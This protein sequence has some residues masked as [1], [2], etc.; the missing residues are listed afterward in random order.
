[1]TKPTKH[2]SIPF[3]DRSEAERTAITKE[4]IDENR[5]VMERWAALTAAEAE[6]WSAR[7]AMA[8]VWLADECS[9]ADLGCATMTLE[10]YLKP[11]QKYIPVDVVARDHR[12]VVCDFNLEAP[13][14]TPAIAAAC[15]GLIEYIHTPTNFMALIGAQYQT[16]VVSYC[17]TD[18]PAAP[19][20]RRANAWVND[21]DTASIEG[22]FHKTGWTIS[23]S[24]WVD[25]LQRIWLLHRTLATDD[26]SELEP[27]LLFGASH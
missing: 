8:A 17:V 24:R 25:D 21:F 27:K 16:T 4:A 14:P 19:Q 2:N 3:Y 23:Q 18:A 5:T 10:R 9:V 12:T 1:M 6:P 7:A 26:T 15:L 22:I 13:P 20:N 11:K